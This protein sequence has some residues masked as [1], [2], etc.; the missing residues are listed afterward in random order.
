MGTEGTGPAV[1]DGGGGQWSDKWRRRDVT[2]K[3]EPTG[4]VRGA[5]D[6]E[7]IERGA[8]RRGT[9]WKKWTCGAGLQGQTGTWGAG[10]GRQDSEC[11]TGGRRRRDGRLFGQA[12][13]KTIMRVENRVPRAVQLSFRVADGGGIQDMEGDGDGSRKQSNGRTGF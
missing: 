8:T 12:V 9:R 2:K 5:R 13:Q 4:V 10:Q 11:R 7:G 6:V 3:G 1:E